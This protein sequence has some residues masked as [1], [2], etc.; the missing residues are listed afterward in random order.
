MKQWKGGLG[1]G[2][3]WGGGNRLSPLLILPS[4][5]WSGLSTPWS[6][7]LSLLCR[8]RGS[9]EG[10][11]HERKFFFCY[12]LLEGRFYEVDLQVMA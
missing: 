9:I 5:L 12:N 11:F 7:D 10:R 1:G 6:E 4:R 3:G 8:R 2:V